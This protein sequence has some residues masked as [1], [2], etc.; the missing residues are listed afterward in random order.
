[1]IQDIHADVGTV[2]RADHK[3]LV[4]A[5]PRPAVGKRARRRLGHRR[6]S[7]VAPVENDEIISKAVHFQKIR[8]GLPNTPKARK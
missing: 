2:G 6:G 4:T 3:D 7:A 8:H 5:D 1:M